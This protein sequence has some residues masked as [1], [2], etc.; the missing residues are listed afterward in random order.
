M[1][2]RNREIWEALPFF[3]LTLGCAIGSGPLEVLAIMSYFFL[4]K[5]Y[6]EL[7]WGMI[8][9]TRLLGMLLLAA[10]AWLGALFFAWCF[11]HGDL[12]VWRDYVQRLIPFGLICVFLAW[13][14]TGIG[15]GL[16]GFRLWNSVFCKR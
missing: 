13:S 3:F 9:R 16:A 6:R 15:R 10:F 11:N 4:A 7:V 1:L 2:E 14:G 5:V 12:Q 8:P